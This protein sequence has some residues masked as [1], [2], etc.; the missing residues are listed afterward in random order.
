MTSKGVLWMA[1]YGSFSIVA[2]AA[3]FLSLASKSFD[4]ITLMHELTDSYKL[5]ILLNFVVCCFLLGGIIS[6][7]LIFGEL[8]LL[9]V[10]KI[11]DQL[12]F[13]GL[14]L[15]FILFNDDNL[16]LNIVWAGITVLA[17]VYHIILLNRLE[18][19]QLQVVNGLTREHLSKLRIFRLFA[20]NVYVILL[21]SFIISDFF[22][23]KILAYDVFQGVS[24]IGSLLFGIQFGVM[25][26]DGFA[27]FGKLAF[28]VYEL[29]F[30][31]SQS[32][33]IDVEENTLDD[34]DLDEN[35]DDDNAETVWE[36]K[37]L[38]TQSFEIIMSALK[39]AFYSIFIYILY[40]H[41]GLAPPIPI[42]QGCFFAA[43]SVAK[44]CLQL[45]SYISQ[46]RILDG[47]LENATTSE[48]EAAD[49]LCII[50]REDMHS[51][52]IYQQQ[53]G[54]A[55]FPR[56]CPKKLQCGHILHMGCLKDWLERSDNCPLCRKKVFGQE[57][58]SVLPVAFPEPV[59]RPNP[60]GEVIRESTMPEMIEMIPY[61]S[62]P[63]IPTDWAAFPIERSDSSG[64][65]RIE[66]SPGNIGVL[67]KR[68]GSDAASEISTSE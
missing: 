59:D 7:R 28:N 26:I 23:A 50:C 40:V 55:L 34:L 37:A 43:V 29:M 14:N 46:S 68:S 53:R 4:Y 45:R 65:I 6:I 3:T 64:Q 41:S 22:L 51:P 11:V 19:L 56:R 31:R 39:A 33:K 30:Y 67:T 63:S 15:L 36:N 49:Y 18:F 17:K 20:L 38:W 62:T 57:P 8:K 27:Y 21:A 9:E 60:P 66:I 2:F 44:Q 12:P 25:G 24:S 35:D 10:E 61:V 42:I 47:L 13:Y 16:L 58:A 1:S 5:T 32:N 54:K 48:L 52:E